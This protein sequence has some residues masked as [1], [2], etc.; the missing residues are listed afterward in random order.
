[1]KMDILKKIKELSTQRLKGVVGL[2]GIFAAL[3]LVAVCIG[4]GGVERLT[5]S[6]NNTLSQAGIS[7][8]SQTGATALGISQGKTSYSTVANFTASSNPGYPVPLECYDNISGGGANGAYTAYPSCQLAKDEVD[9]KGGTLTNSIDIGVFSIQTSAGVGQTAVLRKTK[10]YDPNTDLTNTV[11]SQY[12]YAG[13]A[14][15][16]AAGGTLT[17]QWSCQPYVIARA[18]VCSGTSFGGN[19]SNTSEVS[20]TRYYFQSGATGS[21]F[22]PSGSLGSTNITAPSTAGTYTY[23]LTCNGTEGA[24][25]ISIPVTVTT[26]SPPPPSCPYASAEQP[27]AAGYSVLYPNA[28]RKVSGAGINA[29]LT[30]NTASYFYIPTGTSAEFQAFLNSAASLGVLGGAY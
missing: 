26:S 28:S 24:R 19:C 18:T 16:V 3:M 1:M 30:N 15:S 25:T 14:P 23:S 11:Y 12:T 10:T 21:N 9:P 29:C 4:G 6:T 2:S 20:D 27:F 22:T 7:A 13:S 5:Y 17:M 8:E